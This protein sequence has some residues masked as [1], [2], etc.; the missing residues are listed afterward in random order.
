MELA[1]RKIGERMTPEEQRK[2]I[3]ESL[4]KLEESKH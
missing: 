1:S 3:E 2:L 4:A